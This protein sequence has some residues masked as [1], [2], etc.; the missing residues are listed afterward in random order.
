MT[1]TAELERIAH[2]VIPPVGGTGWRITVDDLVGPERRTVYAVVPVID[3]RRDGRPV[4]RGI[5]RDAHR[6]YELLT[7]GVPT[8]RS[9]VRPAPSIADSSLV[10]T[11]I[12]VDEAGPL[13]EAPEPELQDVSLAI[14]AVTAKRVPPRP[15]GVVGTDAGSM[16]GTTCLVCGAAIDQALTG[17]PRLTCSGACRVALNRRGGVTKLEADTEPTD[18]GSAAAHRQAPGIPAGLTGAGPTPETTYPADAVSPSAPGGG[19]DPVAGIA[20]G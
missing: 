20:S 19:S 1:A 7:S 6:F 10:G 16:P 8:P 13:S 4:F 2:D 17:R 14:P 12:P 5:Q 9:A 15:D 18:G 11:G 3:G